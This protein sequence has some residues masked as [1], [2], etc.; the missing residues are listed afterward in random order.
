MDLRL[1]LLGVNFGLCMINCF[2]FS[3]FRR[4]SETPEKIRESISPLFNLTVVSRYLTS[5]PSPF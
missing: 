1:D 3:G 4:F 5:S 2:G